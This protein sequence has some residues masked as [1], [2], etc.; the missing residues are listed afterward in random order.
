MAD[1]AAVEA[2]ASAFRDS[3]DCLALRQSWRAGA[4]CRQSVPRRS[5]VNTIAARGET[6]SVSARR[7]RGD[8]FGREG[9]DLGF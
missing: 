6:P 4:A 7:L 5:R 8:G 1:L 3:F 2:R 9:V